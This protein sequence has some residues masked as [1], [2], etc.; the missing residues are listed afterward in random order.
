MGDWIAVLVLRTRRLMTSSYFPLGLAG[1]GRSWRRLIQQR[2]REQRPAL[3]G[4][5]L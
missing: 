5:V 1:G 2:V 4:L 3:R